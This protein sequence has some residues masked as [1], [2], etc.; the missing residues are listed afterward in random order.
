[1]TVAAH[2]VVLSA[3]LCCGCALFGNG[4]SSSADGGSPTGG[5]GF[6]GPTLELTVNGMHIGP[7]ALSSGAADLSSER[8]VTTGVLTQSTLR[9][10]AASAAG[11]GCALVFQTFGER[12]GA[13]HVGAFQV[14]TPTATG[15]PDGTVAANPGESVSAGGSSLTCAG[16]DCDGAVL[17]LTALA[18][19]HVEGSFSG[20][21]LD[22]GGQ[23]AGAVVCSFWVPTRTF[24]P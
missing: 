21:L 20:N 22:P 6:S 18:A 2:F 14:A 1:M 5:F 3:L 11:A 12:A 17:Q 23:G 4:S 10:S 15:T 16:S 8:D 7:S 13:F 19:D 9:V 24:Q